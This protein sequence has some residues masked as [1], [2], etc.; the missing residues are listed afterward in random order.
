ME[1]SSSSTSPFKTLP[2]S[3]L[4]LGWSKISPPT[5]PNVYASQVGLLYT[6]AYLGLIASYVNAVLLTYIQWDY[7]PKAGAIAWLSTMT[8]LLSARIC[9]VYSYHRYKRKPEEV[10]VWGLAYALGATAT[11]MCWGSAGILFVPWTSVP[12]QFFTTF[13]LAGVA[14]AAMTVL[15]PIYLAYV[16][17]L[18]PTVTPVVFVF[19]TR[20]DVLHVTAAGLIV[21]Y[22]L[23]LLKAG[24]TQN[25]FIRT[26][27]HLALEKSTLI[28]HLGR[29]NQ[30]VEAL[31][32][33]LRREII[34]RTE[35]ER[36]LQFRLGFESL[37]T[38]IS[39]R[40]I[41]L[42]TD[43]IDRGIVK[44]LGQLTEF[45]GAECAILVLFS[46]DRATINMVLEWDGPDSQSVR[47]ELEGLSLTSFNWSM[48]QLED[49]ETVYIREVGELPPGAAP[50]KRLMQSLGIRSFAAVPLATGAVPLGFL[51]FHSRTGPISWNPEIL[52]LLR[53]VAEM[54]LNALQRKK[55]QSDLEKAQRA[56]EAAAKAKASFLANMSHEIRTPIHGVLGM[57]ALLKQGDLKNTE[58]Q[59]AQTA[60]HSAEI[61]L[62]IIE[63]MLDFS[64][65]EA[66]RMTLEEAELD[67]R[68]VVEEAA[69]LLADRAESKGLILNCLIHNDVPQKVLGD[70]TR[71]RQILVRL[72]SNGVKFTD[73]GW[74]EIRVTTEQLSSANTA[75]LF[76]IC[77]SGIGIHAEAQKS[78]FDSFTQADGS[79]TRRHG[80][81]GLGLAITK[82]LIDLMGG[83]I[84]VESTPGLGSMFSF[85]LSL[86]LVHG[87]SLAHSQ[88]LRG[89]RLLLVEDN[90]LIRTSLVHYLDGWSIQ[91]S[92]TG[93]AEQA[94]QLVQKASV[95]G[96]P[97]ELVLIGR[98]LNGMKP[99]ECAK[100]LLGK[101]GSPTPPPVLLLSPLSRAQ[102]VDDMPPMLTLLTSPVRHA[103]LFNALV[104]RCGE[105][106][107]GKNRDSSENGA[108]ALQ[109]TDLGYSFEGKRILLVEDNIVNQQVAFEMLS[110]IGTE[111]KI[112]ADG[113]QAL[114]LFQSQPFDLVFM[115][116]QMPV[117]DGLQATRLIREF[118][119][120]HRDRVTPIIALTASAMIG[121]REKCISCGMNDY[122]AKPFRMVDLKTM[123]LQWLA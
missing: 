100:A 113:E 17:Y 84:E 105:I 120:Q 115:D 80:G 50:E 98:Q 62:G 99:L 47:G 92:S 57:L 5:N 1:L 102:L 54:F 97:Y 63:D 21:L 66:G 41:N 18:V 58:R 8:V 11:G 108:M 59:Y 76:Q 32:E 112:A 39:T 77:D 121:D 110:V 45:A 73:V 13:V 12:H 36:A 71:L 65:I 51:G 9:L 43:K 116:C 34:E 85:R 86:P 90:A 42:P 10:G 55:A 44:A 88:V 56:A 106:D 30:N 118:E 82:Q 117:M 104:A 3:L 25:Q 123:L 37:L 23:F 61:L 122:L 101:A 93:N 46:E 68:E 107:E 14:A 48:E 33:S 15:S 49:L 87:P 29:Q 119:R 103:A 38:S 111:V 95:A 60:Q 67:L 40:F 91:Y 89:L 26:S 53:M 6:D 75:L 24:K 78:L 28:D 109:G 69:F 27:L 35:T 79:S 74:V 20:G 94:L 22:F 83:Q 70:A 31:N 52:M 7:A 4:R 64:S 2:R 72:L 96:A 81:T 16:G 19:V 114:R